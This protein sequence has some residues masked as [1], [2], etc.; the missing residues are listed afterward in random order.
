M[1]SSCGDVGV[2]P[3]FYSGIYSLPYGVDA[4]DQSDDHGSSLTSATL[5]VLTPLDNDF[6]IRRRQFRAVR[7]A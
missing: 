4:D 5:S 6:H 7:S 2:L 3:A 1:P